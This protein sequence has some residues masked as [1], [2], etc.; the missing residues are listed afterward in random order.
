MNPQSHQVLID[1]R[2]SPEEVTALFFVG[3]NAIVVFA[4][5]DVMLSF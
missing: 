4:K 3:L 2:E 5:E 1:G